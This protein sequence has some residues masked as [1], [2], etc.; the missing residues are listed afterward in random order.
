M[1]EGQWSWVQVGDDMARTAVKFWKLRAAQVTNQREERGLSPRISTN[2]SLLTTA[3]VWKRT[4]SSKK[5]HSLVNS[6]LQPLRQ[7]ILLSRVQISLQKP[8]NQWMLFVTKFESL[9]TQQ[10]PPD[11]LHKCIHSLPR[12]LRT[13]EDS[14]PQ[15]PFPSFSPGCLLVLELHNQECH[16]KDSSLIKVCVQRTCWLYLHREAMLSCPLGTVSCMGK[17]EERSRRRHSKEMVK[18]FAQCG[19]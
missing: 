19:P 13:Q 2:W 5:E 4:R 1:W 6:W 7:K 3:C 15:S 18:W 8:D 17:S 12:A 14:K 9:P 11:S 16:H 10:T